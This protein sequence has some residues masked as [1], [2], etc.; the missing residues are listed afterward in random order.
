MANTDNPH[1]FRPV[2][3]RFGASPFTESFNKVVGY[4]TAIFINDVVHRV[5]DGSIEAAATN[6]TPG[7]TSPSGIALDY[8]AL[9]TATTHLV[10]TD[11]NIIVEAQDNNDTDGFAAADLG[12]NCN[13]EANAGSTVTKISGHELDESTAQT[14]NSLDMHLERLFPDPNNAHGAWSR[15]ECSFNKH[16]YATQ[17]AGI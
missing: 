9:S 11:P 10:I 2:R 15:I 16:R 5:A 3:H 1:G 7:T 14:T 13:L 17:I 4:G 6:F 12:L 8:G